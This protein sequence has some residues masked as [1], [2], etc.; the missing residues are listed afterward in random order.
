MQHI[1]RGVAMGTPQS[2]S[3]RGHVLR[4][5]W[6]LG[7][8]GNWFSPRGFSVRSHDSAELQLFQGFSEG[9]ES[10]AIYS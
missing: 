2:D 8:N 10:S 7:R 5:Q 6:Q 3:I 4:A 1:N 9:P